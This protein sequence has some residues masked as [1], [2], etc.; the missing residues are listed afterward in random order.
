VGPV[1]RLVFRIAVEQRKRKVG[2]LSRA[3]FRGEDE[4]MTSA[5]LKTVLG[6]KISPWLL[7][8]PRDGQLKNRRRSNEQE[9]TL[10]KGGN[11]DGS[12]KARLVL[13]SVLLAAVLL[14]GW[15]AFVLLTPG[16]PVRVGMTEDEI[17]R[18]LKG[19]AREVQ[20]M[21]TIFPPEGKT[22]RVWVAQTGAFSVEFEKG[23]ATTV[24]F[25]STEKSPWQRVREWLGF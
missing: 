18:V 1:W 15:G 10:A 21:Q 14:G 12:M 25:E 3:D 11:L 6:T 8:G 19:K 23:R 9:G 2:R 5:R 22:F 13:A 17:V 4:I 24:E 16:L 7:V 20:T